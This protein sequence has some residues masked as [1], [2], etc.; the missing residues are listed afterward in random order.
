M[1]CKQFR[2]RSRLCRALTGFS[3]APLLLSLCWPH[4]AVG[5]QA[6]HPPA[7][8]VTVEVANLG[9]DPNDPNDVIVTMRV[10]IEAGGNPVVVPDCAENLAPEKG[11][12]LAFLQ[13][14]HHG[15]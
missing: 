9:Q 11:F 6:D 4:Y 12:C 15:K 1:T 8:T 13:R 14:L 10:T 2:K 5:Q 3:A 7:Q